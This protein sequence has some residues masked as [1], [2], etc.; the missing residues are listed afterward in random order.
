MISKRMRLGIKRVEEV[1]S[2]QSQY[3]P[4]IAQLAAHT[5][6]LTK[7]NERE[8]WSDPRV[9]LESHLLASEYYELDSPSTYFDIYNIEAEALGQKLVWIPGE[10]PEIDH[11]YQ[12]ISQPTD[13]DHIKAPDPRQDGRMPFVIELYKR[14]VDMGLNPAIRFCS[15]FSLAANVRGLINLITDIDTRPAFAHRLF[16][17][18]VDEVLAPYLTAIRE[19]CGCNLL[20]LGADALASLPITNPAMIEEFA[21]HYLL[22]LRR[23]IGNVAG[24]GL[25]GESHARDPE[26]IFELKLSFCPDFFFCL[27][28][29]V[30]KIGVEK[31]KAFASKR[32]LPLYLGIDCTLISNG[33]IEDLITRVKEY[34]LAD[35]QKTPTILFLNAVPSETPFQHVHAAVQATHFYGMKSPKE[36]A[37]SAFRFRERKPYRE[38]LS[39][40]D[41]TKFDW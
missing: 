8:F 30:Q 27:D 36:D 17:F 13:L 38:W 18:L 10:F 37:D 32:N 35:P 15:P 6:S 20:A 28:P 33:P 34:I 31:V 5:I 24:F 41:R 21:L 19:E 11:T 22:R 9:F 16:C 4:V 39:S 14:M 29:D 23:A 3:V 26:P 25:W 40:L 1:L 12:L 2:G 7:V